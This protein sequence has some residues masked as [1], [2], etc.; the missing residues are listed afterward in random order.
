MDHHIGGVGGGSARGVYGSG[1][2]GILFVQL[3]NM[4]CIT[5]YLCLSSVRL[6]DACIWITIS[7]AWA[8]V[9]LEGYMSYS[10]SNYIFWACLLSDSDLILTEVSL[11]WHGPPYRR[12]RWGVC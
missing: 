9:L 6:S 10:L 8:R 11:R 4:L 5:I 12:R 2:N 7:E 1:N 3:F